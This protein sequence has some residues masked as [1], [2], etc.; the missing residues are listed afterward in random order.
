MN[1]R[2]RDPHLLAPSARDLLR[3][4]RPGQHFFAS[5][6]AS[7]LGQG[8][9]ASLPPGAANTLAQRAHRWLADVATH[10]DGPAVLMGAVPFAAHHAP[11]L[12]VPEVVLF[13]GGLPTGSAVQAATTQGVR[14]TLLRARP[15]PQGYQQAVQA[16]L[17]RIEAQAFEKVVLSR[18]ITVQAHIDRPALLQHLAARNPLAYCYAVELGNALGGRTLMG[19]SPELLLSKHG[20]TV[21]SHPLAGS[22]PRSANPEEDRR[23]AQALLHSAKERHEHAVVVDAVAT[24]L[25]PFCQQLD[26]PER[27]A[28]VATPTLW[29]LG[30]QVMGQLRDPSVSSLE[31]ALALHPTPAVCGHPAGPAREF[32]TQAE[33]FERGL[34]TGLVGWCTASGNG[35]WAVT[36][37][38]AEVSEQEATLYAGAGI[39]KGSQ[40]EMELAETSAK[41]RTMLQ[42]MGLDGLGLEAEPGA[43]ASAAAGTG[44]SRE[45][46]RGV[47]A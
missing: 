32:I 36:I 8:N 21:C 5:P 41:L 13:G 18:S 26:V 11:S 27:P 4:Y 6:R 37:R 43:Q 22:V 20:P 29:H 25:A 24:A 1:D 33:G 44:V 46:S 47:S 17:E 19:A 28:L 2:L 23:R 38:C 35:E 14:P 3:L 40:P 10:S 9:V 34:F 12:H 39:V 7:L 31:L 15:N 16:A 42:A 45:V 30:T